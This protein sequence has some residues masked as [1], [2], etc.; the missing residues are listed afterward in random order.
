MMNKLFTAATRLIAVATV[1]ASL[2]PFAAQAGLIGSNVTGTLYYP[3]LSTV[4]DGPYGPYT[5]SNS[6]EFP[7]GTLAFDGSVDVTD[8][9]IIWTASEDAIYGDG[10]FNGFKLDFSGATITDVTL[11][12]ATTLTPVGFSFTGDEVLLNLAELTGFEG[13]MTILDV[14]ATA[15]AVP[16]PSTWALLLLG[17]AGLG[18]AGLRRAGRT[19]SVA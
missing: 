14:S 19:A 17:F 2:T 12:S 4:Y 11:D 13:Q 1:A 15:S 10:A 8:T 6:V 5:V 16:E 9:Q 18:Y 3:D 7:V